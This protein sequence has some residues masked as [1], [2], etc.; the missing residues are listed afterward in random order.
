[1]EGPPAT[2]GLF[3]CTFSP[4]S[5]PRPMPHAPALDL[6][7]T[8]RKADPDRWLAS[9][10]IADDD[11]R[12]DVIALY[13]FDHELARAPQV[14]SE[15]LMAEIRLAWWSEALDEIFE[16]RP[17]RAHPVAQG[18]AL[19]VAHGALERSTLDRLIRARGHDAHKA[20]FANEGEVFA[21][22]DDVC[23][24]LMLSAVSL[25]GGPADALAIQSTARGW[26]LATSR[27]L[28]AP[29]RLPPSLTPERMRSL[30]RQALQAARTALKSLPVHA[31]PA[32]A[33]GC[34][35]PAYAEGRTPTVLEKQSRLLWAVLRGSI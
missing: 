26:G 12:A 35:A 5:Y 17:V 7:Q 22:L 32:V 3:S 14:A 13:A 30:T 31:F 28:I 6:D 23:G 21:Y 27:R 10:F 16:G 18:L 2:A 20:P 25:L 33:Y 29:D 19:T 24:A 34:L 4:G 1:M 11:L 9:R 15:P 8:V